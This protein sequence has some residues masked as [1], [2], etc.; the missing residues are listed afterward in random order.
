MSKNVKK[1]KLKDYA[2]I[3]I[4][5]CEMKCDRKVIKGSEGQPIIVCDG[6]K[7]IIMELK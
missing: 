1:I 6:C 4:K 3:G 5:S 2:P 7:R